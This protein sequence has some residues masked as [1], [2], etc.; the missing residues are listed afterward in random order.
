MFK[1]YEWFYMPIRKTI[2]GEMYHIID[3]PFD[4]KSEAGTLAKK[5]AKEYP[6]GNQK[7]IP[8]KTKKYWGVYE[9]VS[10]D[11]MPEMHRHPKE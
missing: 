4:T 8:S 5:R 9:K 10:W 1:P 7:V 2:K 11:H 6:A 3:L